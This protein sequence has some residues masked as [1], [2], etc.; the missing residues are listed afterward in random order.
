MLNAVNKWLF[1]FNDLP[2]LDED[3]N[4]IVY[5]L[6]QTNVKNYTTDSGTL[7]GTVEL[8]IL[9][10]SLIHMYLIPMIEPTSYSGSWL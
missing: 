7:T 8:V 3:G 9:L 2:I 1:T 6:A 4:V 10:S 5:T